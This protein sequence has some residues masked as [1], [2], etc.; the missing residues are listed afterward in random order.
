MCNCPCARLAAY[1]IYELERQLPNRN[2]AKDHG[3][4]EWYE[5]EFGEAR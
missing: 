4:E 1:R 2:Y 5:H 3:F